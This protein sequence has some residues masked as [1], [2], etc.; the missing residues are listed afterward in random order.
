MYF[1]ASFA[2]QIIVGQTIVGWATGGAMSIKEIVLEKNNSLIGEKSPNPIR[3]KE[4]NWYKKSEILLAF[5]L[6]IV[7]QST[8]M[9]KGA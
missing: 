9:A 7:N 6:L 1:I 2:G 5:L 4:E 3:T 8:I